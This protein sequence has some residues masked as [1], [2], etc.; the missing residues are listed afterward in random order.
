MDLRTT[1]K[2]ELHRHLEGAIRLAT[3]Y[4]LSREAGVPLPADSPE[5]LAPR[6]LIREPVDSLEE[7]LKAFAIAQNSLRTY[8]AVRR[9]AREAVEDLHEDGVRLAEL[10]FSPHFM[11]SPGDLDWDV[12]MDALVEGVAEAVADGHD[13]A[14]GLIAIFSRDYGMESARR[15]VEFA[16]RHRDRLVGFD[17]AGSEV[18]Y[19]P[20][21]YA[22]V[23]SPI[24]GSG[25]GLTMHYGE[26]GPPEYP[27]EAVEVLASSRLGHGL[28]VSWDPEVTALVIDRGVTLEMCPTSNWLTRGVAAVD[29][30]P[31]RRLLHDGVKVTLNTDDPGLMGI[32]LLHEWETARDRIGF[33]E[34]D[35]RAVTSNALEASFLP[36][37]VKA[38][39]RRKHFDW[40]ESV[41]R[42]GSG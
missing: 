4:E 33:T 25:L 1:P 21:L 40:L 10:R 19:P 39:V 29:E 42:A 9:I 38:A 2:V 14:V 17:I 18:G 12:A 37:D 36:E 11:C 8:D 31:I 34:D 5:A 27:R 35:F 20:S 26:S 22:D 7:A 15:T 28:S 30:H 32:D 16:L 3:V 41:R 24:R 23:I 13:V 6:A